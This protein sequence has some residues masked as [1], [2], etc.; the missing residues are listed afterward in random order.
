MTPPVK[1]GLL[2]TAGINDPVVKG[3]A[4]SRDIQFLAV[5]SRDRERAREWAA[6]HQI[7]RAFGSYS[8]LLNDPDV[9]A[10]YISLPNSMHVE[11]SIRALEAGKHVLCEKPLGRDPAQVTNAFDQADRAGRHLVEAF[12][13]RFHRQ[14]DEIRKLIAAGAIG[15]L[16]HIRA[17]L[18]FAMRSP[19]TDVRTSASLDGGALM[20]LGCYCLSAFRLFAGKPA[21][22]DGYAVNE[23]FAVDLRFLG[24]LAAENGVTGQFDCGMTLPRRDALELVGEEGR[25]VVPDPWHCRGEP[26]AVQVR[27]RDMTVSVDPQDAYRAEFEAVSR[28]IHA[29]EKLEFGRDDA[30]AQAAALA[31]LLESAEEKRR[32]RP[33][34]EVPTPRALARDS[35]DRPAV[36]AEITR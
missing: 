1:W 12:M 6:N 13:Y 15:P 35:G 23:G 26:F 11:W 18:S 2:S 5:A 16:K 24:T 3:C 28:A 4:G 20:D 30:V 33:E 31:T 36:S 17:T 34:T 21:Y 9:E 14:T 8:E 19:D 32:P 7:P 10:V 25:I 29:G 22:L 27:D